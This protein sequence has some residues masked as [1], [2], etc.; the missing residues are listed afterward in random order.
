MRKSRRKAATLEGV[1]AA[2]FSSAE[3]RLA[4]RQQ[5]GFDARLKPD[6]MHALRPDATAV[7]L[8][9]FGN[10]LPLAKEAVER[11]RKP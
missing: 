4:Q 7:A 9:R 3:Q 8:R 1:V 11:K 2:T 5:R 6:R 10:M